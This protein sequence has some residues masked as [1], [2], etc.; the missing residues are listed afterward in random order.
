MINKGETI[1]SKTREKIALL[2][3]EYDIELST[4]QKILLSLK[5]PVTTILDVLYGS[6]N[7]FVLDQ[8]LEEADEN[9]SELID[10]DEGATIY[11]REVIVH[12]NGRPLVYTKS[13]IPTS[14]CSDEVI[15]DLHQS[16]L[17]TGS[18]MEKNEIET[19][20]LINEISIEE[21]DGLMNELF[22]TDELMITRRYVM[23]QHKK[24]VIW[25][26][27]KYPISYFRED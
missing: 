2:E 27:E 17:T 21:P 19:L 6:M 8:H 10:I 11:H 3:E 5:G 20:R 26:E 9:I 24:P 15:K 7:L 16:H 23:V 14:R 4:T 25:T 18:I 22:H 12:K 1:T 13:Y